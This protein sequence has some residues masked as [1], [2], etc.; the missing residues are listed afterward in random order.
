MGSIEEAPNDGDALATLDLD[1][2][3]AISARYRSAA[4]FGQRTNFAV[5]ESIADTYVHV[6]E[7][8]LANFD[9]QYHYHPFDRKRLS[10]FTKRREFRMP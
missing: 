10:R 5:G 9:N 7:P 4:T 6:R 3:G 8:R 1:A 2:E